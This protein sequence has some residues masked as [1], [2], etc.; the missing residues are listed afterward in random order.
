MNYS[1]ICYLVCFN[2]HFKMS[3]FMWRPTS[4]EISSQVSVIT[5]NKDFGE[6]T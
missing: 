5:D 3:S 1:P 2:T 4:D 6:G